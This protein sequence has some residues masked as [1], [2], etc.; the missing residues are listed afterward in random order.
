MSDATRTFRIERVKSSQDKEKA[1]VEGF[2]YTLDLTN[3]DVLYWVCERRGKCNSRINTSNYL[4]IKPNH[5]AQ[6]VE[7]HTHA[8]ISARIEMIKCYSQ[9]K[10]TAAIS[11]QSTRLFYLLQLKVC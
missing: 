7:D 6:N 1:V 5:I 11:E 2:V 3:G 4:I 8:P 9:L 10:T